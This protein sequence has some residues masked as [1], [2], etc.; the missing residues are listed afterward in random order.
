[1][2]ILHKA[3][4]NK[5]QAL[6]SAAVPRAYSVYWQVMGHLVIAMLLM[7]SCSDNQHVQTYSSFTMLLLPFSGYYIR[8][9][10]TSSKEAKK[11]KNS[12]SS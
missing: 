9:Y 12:I 3:N 8:K 1:M 11:K 5:P 7:T 6:P 2:H 10:I 4:N